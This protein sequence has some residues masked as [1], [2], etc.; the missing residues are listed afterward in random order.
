MIHLKIDMNFII[1]FT[2]AI[3]VIT[4]KSNAFDGTF[5]FIPCRHLHSC[6][7]DILILF[8]S[9]CCVIVAFVRFLQ[10][11]M[12]FIIQSINKIIRST[13]NICRLPSFCASQIYHLENGIGL[14]TINYSFQCDR[15]YCMRATGSNI[16]LCVSFRSD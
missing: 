15:V 7:S 5:R 12:F 6:I 4:N 3:K 14:D 8:A 13:L 1:L 9:R 16:E 2:A 10:N 11:I